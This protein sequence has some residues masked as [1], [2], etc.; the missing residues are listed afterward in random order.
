MQPKNDEQ[1][2]GK[3]YSVT[4]D[5]EKETGPI[6]RRSHDRRDP[7]AAGAARASAD[8]FYTVSKLECANLSITRSE[9]LKKFFSLTLF[10]PLRRR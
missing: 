2:I 7:E 9:A 3:F 10:N 6:I 5:E 8:F 1:K 4:P